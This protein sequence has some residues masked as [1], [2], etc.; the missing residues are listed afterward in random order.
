MGNLKNVSQLE[1]LRDPDKV[2]YLMGIHRDP[3]NFL[4]GVITLGHLKTK[5]IEY[6]IF[7]IDQWE[8]FLC[9]VYTKMRKH[10]DISLFEANLSNS[11]S[12][13]MLEYIRDAFEEM[14]DGQYGRLDAKNIFIKIA[15]ELNWR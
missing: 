8:G 3:I 6:K 4:D 10:T 14:Y 2:L 9:A 5:V 12:Y 15:L 7:E 11:I 13:I 1:D